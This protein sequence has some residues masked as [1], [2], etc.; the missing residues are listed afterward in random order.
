MILLKAINRSKLTKKIII[1]KRGN[2]KT[3]WVKTNKKD[4]DTSTIENAYKRINKMDST[5]LLYMGREISSSPVYASFNDIRYWKDEF[6]KT[7]S[8]N[9]ENFNAI[10]LLVMKD[11]IS[12]DSGDK[13]RDKHGYPFV[14]SVAYYTYEDGS[15]DYINVFSK[16]KINTDVVGQKKIIK[17]KQ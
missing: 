13:A 12:F 16:R 14:E 1:D 17:E 2:K 4:S 3:V 9:K 8:F 6:D 11:E 10:K 5:L 15:F 7:G